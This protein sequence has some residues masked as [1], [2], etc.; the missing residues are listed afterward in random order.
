MNETKKEMKGKKYI[1]RSSLFS[2]EIVFKYD[3]NGALREIIFPEKLSFSH[4]IWIG[5][6]L[7]YNESIIS[8]M[9]STRA[10]FSIEEI[11][12]DLSFNRFWIDYQYKVG[13]KKMAESIWNRM[14]LSDRIKALSYIPK[15]LDHIKRT[16]HDQ[17]YPTTYL[18]QRYF[19]S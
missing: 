11:P 13:K 16:G 19:D 14:S 5:R 8:K 10:S 2:G 12:I 15:Y 7:P 4:Y 17:A 9:K 6:F 1:F 18:N 3:L